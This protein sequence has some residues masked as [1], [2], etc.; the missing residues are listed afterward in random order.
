MPKG[1]EFNQLPKSNIASGVVEDPFSDNRKILTNHGE[2]EGLI[3]S[4]VEKEGKKSK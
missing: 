1:K 2:I 4:P 3:P